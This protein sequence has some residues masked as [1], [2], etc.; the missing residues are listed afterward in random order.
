M[1]KKVLVP[2]ICVLVLIIIVI[3]FIVINNSGISIILDIIQ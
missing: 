3:G 2:T 1:K